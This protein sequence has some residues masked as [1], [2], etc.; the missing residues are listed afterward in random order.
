MAFINEKK[1]WHRRESVW[2]THPVIFPWFSALLRRLTSASMNRIKVKEDKWY[3]LSN[4]LSGEIV[5]L[6]AIHQKLILY[7]CYIT[8]YP[9]SSCFWKFHLL[10]NSSYEVPFHPVISF[11]HVYFNVN[12]V[13]SSSRICS[14]L[15]NISWAI[16]RLCVICLPT[17]KLQL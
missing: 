1:V 14:N 15:M 13:V 16:I 9:V 17:I 8:H 7:R 3:P 10:H 12:S 5:F 4:P 2:N 6:L 11:T